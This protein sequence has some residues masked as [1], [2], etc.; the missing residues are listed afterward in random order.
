MRRVSASSAANGSSI[1]STLGSIASARAIAT[2]CF[3][4]P[5]SMC[6]IHVL[7][8]GE[9]DLGEQ[10]ARVLLRPR[11][12]GIRRLTSSGNMTLPQHRLPRQQLVEF[13]EHHHAVGAGPLDRPAGEP[14]RALDRRHEAGDRLQ[15][16][17]LAAAGRPEHHEAL[18]SK[19]SKPTRQVAVTRCSA[20]LYCSVTSSTASKRS[21]A[22]PAAPP[23]SGRL[24]PAPMQSPDFLADR[25]PLSDSLPIGVSSTQ[26][27]RPPRPRLG[28]SHVS[29]LAIVAT[30][31]F[32]LRRRMRRAPRQRRCAS[33]SSSA[34]PTC[35][36]W[37]WRTRS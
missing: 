26:A 4:P 11:A 13:L 15:Q 18:A 25:D 33:P 5:D 24:P 1:S 30:I 12:R 20:V 22:P 21:A 8:A 10:R 29:R 27:E 7:E 6:G 14:D 31:A 32:A 37:S 17:R 9:V 16:G 35:S 28:G 23:L 36:S 2:R 3:M 34:S 19:T